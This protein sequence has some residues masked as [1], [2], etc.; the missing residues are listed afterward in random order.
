MAKLKI[1]LDAG[2]GPNTPG[3]R[4]PDGSLREYQFN[5]RVADVMKLKF[6][7]YEGVQVL[8]THSDGRDVPL[9]ERTNAA[10]KWGAN[11]VVSLHAN[12]NAGKMGSHGGI[13]TFIYTKPSAKSTEVAKAVQ[14]ALIKATGLRD[15]SVKKG[16]LHMVREPKAPSILVEYGFMDSYTDLPLLKTDSYRILCAETTVNAI[17]KVYGLKRKG[18]SK[19]GTGAP[20]PTDHGKYRLATGT[21]PSAKAMSE[22]KAKLYAKYPIT[23]Y[24]RAS[25]NRLI[26]GTFTGRNVAEYYA[27]EIKKDFGWHIIVQEAV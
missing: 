19:T 24:E 6:S 10:N 15:R 17:A 23:I 13:E 4:S 8:F 2:H 1:V 25:D 27:K 12:A 20:K 3:K 5:K 21:F 16:N 26:T 7:D 11:L 18:A 22:G 14:S 9:S